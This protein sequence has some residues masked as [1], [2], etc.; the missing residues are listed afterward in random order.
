MT[1]VIQDTPFKTLKV[2]ELHPTFA[3]EVEGVDWSNV[4]D[5]Q[6]E[7]IKA[8]M[9]KYGVCVFRNT[10]LT[11]DAHVAFSQRLGD[12]D[13]V[14]R[15]LQGG[16]KLRYAH[17]ELFDAGNLDDAGQLLDRDSPR[18]HAGRGNG[19]FHSDS[20]FNPRRASYSLLRAVAIPPPGTGGDTEFCDTRAAWDGLPAGTRAELLAG[21]YAGA[22]C[23]AQSRKL[24]SPAYFADVDPAE[25][26]MALHRVA[27]LHEPSGRMVLYV[28]AHMHHLERRA[29]GAEALGEE[30]SAALVEALNAHA[31]R[32]EYRV[33]VGWEQPGDMVIW[34]NRCT[35][36]RAAGGSFEG[37]FG[38]DMRR[39]TVHDDGAEAW[40]L[41]RVGEEMP[42]PQ[43][44]LKQSQPQPQTVAP[45]A[46]AAS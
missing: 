31:S 36:H 25:A 29:P 38:R 45:T 10:G 14:K 21:G 1:G 12:L 20:S 39:T 33:S 44:W 43:S 40:G 34:D 35:L 17:A 32:E 30:E 15:Y 13:N 37:R 5:E 19:L 22:H 28:G 41:N 7:E 23:L 26:P 46:V 18:A 4:T 8:A 42:G 24:G 3:A 6:L 11:D 16:R 2:R 9:A 27:Q